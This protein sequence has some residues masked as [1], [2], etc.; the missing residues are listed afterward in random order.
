M[1]ADGNSIEFIRDMS[2]KAVIAAHASSVATYECDLHLAYH[3]M[4][5]SGAYLD[6]AQDALRRSRSDS[7]RWEVDGARR[8]LE[9]AIADY[10]EATGSS[11][12]PVECF[13][14]SR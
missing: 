13:M 12:H 9:E 4:H 2:I 11:V 7:G 3:K 1:G 14:E 5:V 10:A 8:A 6:A